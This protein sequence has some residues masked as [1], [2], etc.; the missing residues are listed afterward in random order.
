MTSH[1]DNKAWV[2]RIRTQG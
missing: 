2:M 1:K